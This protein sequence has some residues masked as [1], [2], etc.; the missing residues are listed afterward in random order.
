MYHI[1]KITDDDI[2]GGILFRM[3]DALDQAFTTSAKSILYEGKRGTPQEMAIYFDISRFASEAASTDS[4]DTYYIND[5]A[6]DAMERAGVKLSYSGRV[7]EPPKNTGTFCR[8][9]RYVVSLH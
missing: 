3:T 9:P 1:A 4:D 7:D 2:R 6:K 5:A 8:M